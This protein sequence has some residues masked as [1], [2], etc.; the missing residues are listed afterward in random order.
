MPRLTPIAPISLALILA[1]C[2]VA[3][4]PAG[5]D[6]SGAPQDAW[7][8]SPAAGR[9]LVRTHCAGCHAVERTDESP[10]IGAPPFCDMGSAYPASDLQEAF[11]EG[12]VTAHPAMPQFE[13][14]TQQIADLIAYMDSLS[15]LSV[16][17]PPGLAGT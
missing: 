17:P 11:A 6:M 12:I 2:M 3:A 13:F 14:T 16:A 10:L 7:S 15:G 4:A 1:G 8:G 9:M 5:R